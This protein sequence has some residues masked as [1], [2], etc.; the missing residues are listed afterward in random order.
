MRFFLS[1][2]EENGRHEPDGFFT[3][4]SEVRLRQEEGR[5]IISHLLDNR[6]GEL[7]LLEAVYLSPTARQIDYCHRCFHAKL[8]SCV[9]L[10]PFS[11]LLAVVVG[12]TESSIQPTPNSCR[13]FLLP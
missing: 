13:G 12:V 4:A 10:G 11:L 8:A 2:R 1:V 5:I 9:L 6:L 3:F 7:V